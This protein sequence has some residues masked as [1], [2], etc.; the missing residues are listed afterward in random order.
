MTHR[1]GSILKLWEWIRDHDDTKPLVIRFRDGLVVVGLFQGLLE[2]EWY[3]FVVKGLP[4][5]SRECKQGD[6]LCI[7]GVDVL[8]IDGQ[9]FEPDPDDPGPGDPES[10]RFPLVSSGRGSF[11]DPDNPHGRRG[12]SDE[13]PRVHPAA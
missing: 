3:E 10:D 2:E 8:S 11:V 6:K 7:L 5:G 12:R 4:G 9:E 13:A 1:E